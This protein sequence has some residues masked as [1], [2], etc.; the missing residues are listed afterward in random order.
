MK[1]FLSLVAIPG[2]ITIGYGEADTLSQRALGQLKLEQERMF[3]MFSNGDVE[4]FRK[5]SGDDYMTINA[6]GTYMDK[7]QA[8]ELIPKFKGSTYEI[9]EQSDRVYGNIVIST[10]R[11][12]FYF[13][14]LLVA[15]VYF[16]Q[17]WVY[18]DNRWQFI[19]W[20]GTMTGTPRMYPVYLT[21]ILTAILLVI[22]FVVYR[23]VRK[24]K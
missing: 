15:D 13:S 16:N 11:A 12:K 19:N 17:T 9:I 7:T 23:L 3:D 10:G 8:I 21:L 6:D 18:R 20:Q 24:R 5:L 2:L 22:G 4:T 1:I 14:S